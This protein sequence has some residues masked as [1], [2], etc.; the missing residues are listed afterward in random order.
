MT[1]IRT[2]I[3]ETATDMAIYAL[4]RP[5]LLALQGAVLMGMSVSVGMSTFGLS[6]VFNFPFSGIFSVFIALI[7]AITGIGSA[8]AFI[9]ATGSWWA[10][11]R[12][13][14]ICL[15]TMIVAF[16]FSVITNFGG[17]VYMAEAD[18][19]SATVMTRQVER[20]AD[21]ASM[22]ADRYG[23]AAQRASEVSAHS[24]ERR[25]E[26][27]AN[28]GTCGVDAGS[29]RGP[30]WRLRNSDAERTEAWNAHF[31]SRRD[32]ARSL[33][34]AIAAAAQMEEAGFEVMRGRVTDAWRQLQN[35]ARDPEIMRISQAVSDR[36][37]IAESGWTEEGVRYTCPDPNLEERLS[38]LANALDIPELG[39]APAFVEPSAEV[40]VKAAYR[41]IP[42]Y[43]RDA[44]SVIPFIPSREDA[45]AARRATLNGS[46]PE[47]P[48][49]G[50]TAD[51]P[52]DDS[53]VWLI[54]AASIDALVIVVTFLVNSLQRASGAFDAPASPAMRRLLF[55][56]RDRRLQRYK[57]FMLP[58]IDTPATWSGLI[59]A[60]DPWLLVEGKGNRFRA[61]LPKSSDNPDVIRARRLLQRLAVHGVADHILEVSASQ[62]SSEER[63]RMRGQGS[64]IACVFR[65]DPAFMRDVH[66]LAQAEL[67]AQSDW[68]DDKPTREFP[69]VN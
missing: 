24:A 4:R 6:S 41:Q 22:F 44:L 21:R 16:G 43:V 7:F 29:G 20:M 66:A 39:D 45:R 51:D 13:R 37:E 12:V 56:A 64:R 8:R 53:G 57:C 15:V 69:Q 61:V 40:M 3:A 1:R 42:E 18:R 2:L 49:S 58:G 32:E 34:N 30:R 38:A 10:R 26:E 5:L 36:L 23:L 46:E 63:E 47:V 28:G 68:N 50:P 33:A 60:L 31:A 54:W 27:N 62:L 25:T 48:D 19:I 55:L 65:L 17:F 35:L 59:D 9:T 67:Q 11:W 52:L 14:A